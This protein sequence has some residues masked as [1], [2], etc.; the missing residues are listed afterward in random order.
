MNKVDIPKKKPNYFCVYNKNKQKYEEIKYLNQQEL[1][2][3]WNQVIS[4]RSNKK[5]INHFSL[6]LAFL[7]EKYWKSIKKI[8]KNGEEIYKLIK[9]GLT[10]Y[11]I[12]ETN[13]DHIMIN[14]FN[15]LKKSCPDKILIEEYLN[16]LDQSQHTSWLVLR[17]KN[18]IK[19]GI[20]FD[21][22]YVSELEDIDVTR[23][24]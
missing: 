6:T 23:F 13:Q 19:N 15:E 5:L 1:A 10:T 14:L 3:G 7:P 2:D 20:L 18:Y 12:I 17:S 16:E 21:Q 9:D 24:L 8:K 22:H 11:T 4:S